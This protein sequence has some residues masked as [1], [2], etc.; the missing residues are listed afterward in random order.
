[1]LP[2][3]VVAAVLCDDIRQ[4]QNSKHILIGVYNGGVV[5]PNFPAEFAV[6]WWMQILPNEIGKFEIDV[7]LVKD[8]RDVLL[9]A[10]IGFEI[11]AREWAAMVLPRIPLQLYGEGHLQLQMKVHTESNWTTVQDFDVKKGNVNIGI[12]VQH[13]VG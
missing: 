11:H 1:M 5:V 3:K 7:Q 9:K 4:E 13:I 10:G 2:F 8:N 6:C 12:P